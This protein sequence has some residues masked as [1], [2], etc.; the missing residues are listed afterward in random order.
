MKLNIGPGPHYV[1]GWTNV[2]VAEVEGEFHADY[3]LE[4]PSVLPFED[5]SI[6]S[7]YCGHILEHI[8]WEEV[9]PYLSE[10]YR[11]LAPGGTLLIVGPDIMKGLHLWK[12]G[13]IQFHF[14]EKDPGL[15]GMFEWEH[16]P[17]W[18]APRHYWNCHEKRVISILDVDKWEISPA[19]MH[20]SR[21]DTWPITSRAGWQMAVFAVKK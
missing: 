17:G 7:V 13:K 15:L 16:L 1:D 14:D 21:L 20:D 19:E 10:V 12:A 6:E 11:V 3:Y 2:E 9:E 18:T 8:I 5:G 4:D